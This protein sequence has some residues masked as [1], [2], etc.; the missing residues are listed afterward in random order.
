[1]AIHTRSITENVPASY[2]KKRW[3]LAPDELNYENG[4][5]REEWERIIQP[6]AIFS[7]DDYL[8]APRVGRGIRQIISGPEKQNDLFIVG[9]GRLGC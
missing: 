4:F 7:V 3:T 5:F 2:G 8:K 1:M 6:Q 9:D